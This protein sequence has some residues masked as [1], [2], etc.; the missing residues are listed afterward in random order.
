MAFGAHYKQKVP[1]GS[2]QPRYAGARVLPSA[3][4]EEAASAADVANR[5]VST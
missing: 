3:C 4:I 5:T 1:E 2:M